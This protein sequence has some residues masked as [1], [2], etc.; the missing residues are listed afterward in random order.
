M[1]EQSLLNVTLNMNHR[2]RFPAGEPL[3]QLPGARCKRGFPCELRGGA[4][5]VGLGGSVDRLACARRFSESQD[6]DTGGGSSSPDSLAW[7]PSRTWAA[8]GFPGD[9][10]AGRFH[11]MPFVVSAGPGAEPS[12]P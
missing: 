2:R 9:G 6:Q 10:M 7:R 5:D 4:W 12:G 3:S 11:K 1:V 8:S